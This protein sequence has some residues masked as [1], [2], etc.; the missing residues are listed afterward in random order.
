MGPSSAHLPDPTE[1]RWKVVISPPNRKVQSGHSKATTVAPMSPPQPVHGFRLMKAN[2]HPSP[3][4]P[5]SITGDVS[6][7][8]NSTNCNRHS[9]D[10]RVLSG[11]VNEAVT[12]CNGRLEWLCEQVTEKSSSRRR[13][14]SGLKNFAFFSPTIVYP[15]LSKSNRTNYL[16]CPNYFKFN[17]NYFKY[18]LIQNH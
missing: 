9:Q 3:A 1:Y 2:I 17:T 5:N 10:S 16:W 8:S 12:S 6:V 13:H 15:S 18:N 4:G 7:G 11:T 14:V